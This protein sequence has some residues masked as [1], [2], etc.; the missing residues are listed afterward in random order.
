V[1]KQQKT[2]EPLVWNDYLAL[3]AEDHCNDQGPKGVTGH[4]GTD[5]SSPFD[6]MNRYGSW[7]GS[8]AENLAYGKSDGEGFMLQLYIDDGVPDRG[9]RKAILNP[10]LKM[11]GMHHCDHKGYGGM[12]AVAYAVSFTPS[13]FGKQ[14]LDARA[15]I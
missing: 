10:N 15:L 1:L 12:L 6:R 8:A 5:G 2:F 9:H 4:G 3:A 11:V 14:E 13:T 7:G